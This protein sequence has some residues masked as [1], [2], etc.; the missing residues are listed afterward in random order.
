MACSNAAAAGS[1][2]L[3]AFRSCISKSPCRRRWRTSKPDARIWRAGRCSIS[4]ANGPSVSRR[5]SPPA[6]PRYAEVVDALGPNYERGYFLYRFS[7]PSYVVAHALVRAV[8]GVALRDGGR[9]IDI[10]GGSGHLTRALMDLS[11][12]PPVLA[13]LY[14]AKVWLGR[15]FTA[16]GCEG[17]CCHAEAPMPFRRGAFSYAMCADAFMFIWTK[18][19]FV[20]EMLRLVDLDH[21]VLRPRSACVVQRSQNAARE[22]RTACRRRDQPHAQSAAVERVARAGAAAR[23]LSRAVRD[24]RASRVQRGGAVCGRREGRTARSGA[25]RFSRSARGRS[26]ADDRRHAQ[27]RR[28][29]SRTR[30]SRSRERRERSG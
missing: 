16:P 17:V 19:R 6:P 8:A 20:Q 1:R 24:H 14:F 30:S 25:E 12:Q 4:T 10:C 9:A 13:D 7:D 23:R 26:G 5:S 29:Q 27:S 21:D 18:R 11:S 22:R 28:V 15:Q 2:S 3:P